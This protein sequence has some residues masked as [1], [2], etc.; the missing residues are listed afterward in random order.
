MTVVLFED[1]L[2]K[3]RRREVCIHEAAHAVIHALGGSYVYL[4]AVA[5]E[6]ATEWQVHDRR[7]GLCT[8]LW[9][10]CSTSDFST[11]CIRWNEAEF[12]YEVDRRAYAAYLRD[13]ERQLNELY[14]SEGRPP[15]R[16]AAEQRRIVRAHICG[17]MAGPAADAIAAGEDVE[18][19]L[20]YWNADLSDPDEDLCNAEAMAR[21]LPYRNEYDHAVRVTEEAL[22]RPAIWA[23][24]L[25]LADE[26]ERVGH[27]EDVHPW[28]PDADRHWPPSPRRAVPRASV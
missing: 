22:R 24:V 7:G 2:T 12:G 9:G 6:D 28:L 16:L 5:P 10:L 11:W 21:L 3:E 8:G 4:L 26:L 17:S 18:D 19:A 1:R 15:A 23:S 14:R 13:L 25:N 20:D 27:M